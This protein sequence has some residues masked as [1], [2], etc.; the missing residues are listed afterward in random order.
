MKCTAIFLIAASFPSVVKADEAVE[1]GLD[2]SFAQT[3][4]HVN[5]T[6]QVLGDRKKV[7][8]DYI[9]G[10]RDYWVE[11]SF[12]CDASEGERFNRNIVQPQSMVVSG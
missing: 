2:V 7:Y 11:K 1:Y 3:S 9:Q 12:L 6:V 10:C 4:E 5:T 8:E